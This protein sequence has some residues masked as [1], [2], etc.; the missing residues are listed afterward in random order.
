M[1]RVAS[2]RLLLSIATRHTMLPPPPSRS[3]PGF[4][5][6]WRHL[7]DTYTPAMRRYVATLVRGVSG[8]A[9]EDDA[10]DVVQ[11]YLAS[12]LEGGWLA[13]H[14]DR[15]RSFRSFLKMQ[16]FRFTCDWIEARRAKK[17]TAPGTEAPP[18]ALAAAVGRGA[19][20]ADADFDAALVDAAVGQ[21]LSRLAQRSEDQAE[22]VREL[23]RTAGEP[24]NDLGARLGREPG[25]LAALVRRAR[26]AFAE[27]LA[28]TL[29]ETV[30]DEEAFADLIADLE[31]RLP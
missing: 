24:G 18:E 15:I 5:R 30:R 29:R 27:L 4:E 13:V 23:L 10:D 3:D 8:A 31:A 28:E 20:P 6:S 17:R 21:A 2:G 19:G 25:A 14:A 9:A 7:F 22:V 26:V 12:A 16:L 11:A 1:G